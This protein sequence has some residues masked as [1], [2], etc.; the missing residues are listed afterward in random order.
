M[1]SGLWGGFGWSTMCSK[2]LWVFKG[3]IREGSLQGSANSIAFGK[4]PRR[5]ADSQPISQLGRQ[6]V[7]QAVSRANRQAK[8]HSLTFF[9][10]C[11]L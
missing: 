5:E 1:W 9:F 11:G 4:A 3:A 8:T 7:S 10:S 6:A 2:V